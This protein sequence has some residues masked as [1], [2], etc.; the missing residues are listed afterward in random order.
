MPT[1]HHA[2]VSICSGG[3]ELPEYEDPDMQGL[4]PDR[5]RKKYI[6]AHTGAEFSIKLELLKGFKFGP[7]QAAT[8]DYWFDGSNN[9]GD[10]LIIVPE[11]QTMNFDSHTEYHNNDKT[12]R[13]CKYSFGSLNIAE[14]SATETPPEVLRGLGTITVCIIRGNIVPT[15]HSLPMDAPTFGPTEV[16]EKALKGKAIEYSIQ[17]VRDE[18]VG[19]PPLRTDTLDPA[20]GPLGLPLVFK[21]SYRSRGALQMLHCIPRSPSHSRKSS[22]AD[23]ARTITAQSGIGNDQ[24][25]EARILEAEL[26][27]IEKRRTK[28]ESAL[29]VRRG[30]KRER[31]SDLNVKIEGSTVKRARVFEEGEMIDLTSD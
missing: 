26:A 24:G 11:H 6:E 13:K 10:S 2:K 19:V 12:W 4:H 15:F 29:G 14:E 17:G 8:I 22:E 16:S 20:L 7:G 5:E 27:E 9:S 3:R 25:D 18:I 31:D 21:F 28:I 23:S 30:V 1:L